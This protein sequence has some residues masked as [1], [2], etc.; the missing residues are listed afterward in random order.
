METLLCNFQPRFEVLH[1]ERQAF[2]QGHLRLPFQELLGLANVGLPLMRVIGG[3]VTESDSGLGID[4]LLH[5]L[6]QRENKVVSSSA[7]L[8]TYQT[9]AL[10]IGR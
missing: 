9:A 3:V 8:R 2:S 1:H 5:N 10:T 4:H 7:W 6:E